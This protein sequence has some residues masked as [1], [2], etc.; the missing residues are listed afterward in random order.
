M[1]YEVISEYTDRIHVEILRR[2]INVGSI[3]DNPP[4]NWDLERIRKLRIEM[5]L[6]FESMLL[7]H[8]TVLQNGKFKAQRI[9]CRK[10]LE[11]IN[12]GL[13]LGYFKK[14]IYA[15]GKH[16]PSDKKN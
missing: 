6:L 16:S 5:D 8:E 9:H 10:I 11:E 14:L 15:K 7:Y 4:E 2:R 3:L 13:C 1:A 12:P